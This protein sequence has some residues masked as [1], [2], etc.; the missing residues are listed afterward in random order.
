MSVMCA[1]CRDELSA[2]LDGEDDPRLRAAVDAH[3]AS[4]TECRRWFDEAARITRLARTSV[5][6]PTPDLVDVVRAAAPAARC[7]WWRPALRVV[8]ALAGLGQL[9][10]AVVEIAAGGAH[11]GGGEMEGA[12]MLHFAHES[13][14]WNLALGVGFLWIAWRVGRA[15]G[16]V[17]TLTAFVVV[18]A[19]LTGLDFLQ[20]RVDPARLAS[21][22]LVFIG[23]VAVLALAATDTGGEFLP[24]G[25][26]VR[27]AGAARWVT[28]GREVAAEPDAGQDA[29]ADGGLRPT[30]RRDAA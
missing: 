29:G 15:A 18:L 26:R 22:A 23:Y 16:L 5:A 28:L 2:R 24:R 25:A 30:A 6:H 3:L 27:L 10:L 8:L 9:A 1:D 19:T 21:H 13:A 12:S 4:C 14:A 11:G 17:P 20:G 7:A